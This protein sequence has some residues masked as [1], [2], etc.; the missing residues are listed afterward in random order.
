MKERLE[1]ALKVTNGYDLEKIKRLDNEGAF[2]ELMKFK[3]IERWTAELIL[4]T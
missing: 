3:G 4:I 1:L 2:E